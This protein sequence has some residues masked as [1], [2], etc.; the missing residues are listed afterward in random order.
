VNPQA[1]GSSFAPLIDA[2]QHNRVH[3]FI[4]QGK[5]EAKL[6][7]GGWR[8]EKPGNFVPPTLFTDPDPNAAIYKDEIFG[9]VLV[10]RRFKDEDEVIELAND[11][12]YGLAGMLHYSSRSTA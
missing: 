12:S 7:T 10:I 11:S 1:Y 8:Y 2:Q 9:P 5:K 4:E 3:A 6:V